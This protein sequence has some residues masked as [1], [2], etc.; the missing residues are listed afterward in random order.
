MFHIFN[1]C[2]KL[3]TMDFRQK[4]DALH[5]LVLKDIDHL[6]GFLP[7]NDEMNTF[8]SALKVNVKVIASQL[9]HKT[10]SLKACQ[11]DTNNLR[12][13]NKLLRS[14]LTRVN[15][16]NARIEQTLALN[17]TQVKNEN[18]EQN[19]VVLS[20][21]S[22]FASRE[23][24]LQEEKIRVER[25][26]WK[27][28]NNLQKALL[29]MQSESYMPNGE[30]W[31]QHYKKKYYE[32]LVIDTETGE[33]YICRDTGDALTRATRFE[34]ERD[35]ALDR[36]SRAQT[37]AIDFKRRYKAIKEL[38]LQK[39]NEEEPL[40]SSTDHEESDEELK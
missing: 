26:Y 32:Q 33:P 23:Q 7:Q 31:A 15:E 28:V 10:D 34:H 20:I 37:K 2:F 24:R 27:E 16:R 8:T 5:A 3:D 29:T 39:Y 17:G 21:A 9:I 22:E 40:Q 18:E 25:Y 4:V 1:P 13:E 6:S 30:T 14:E 12:I 11:E 38:L 36:L 35:C 19:L